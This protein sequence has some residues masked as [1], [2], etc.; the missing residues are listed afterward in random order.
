V[1]SC[2]KF[3]E[4]LPAAQKIHAFHKC[5]GEAFFPFNGKAHRQG[6]FLKLLE[7]RLNPPD[8]GIFGNI[9]GISV[10]LGNDRLGIGGEYIIGGVGLGVLQRPEYSFGLG[11]IVVG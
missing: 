4:K 11:V 10:D 1:P 5:I 8:V 3:G 7:Y 2:E 9:N 6:G